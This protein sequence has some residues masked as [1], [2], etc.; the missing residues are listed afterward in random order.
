MQTTHSTDRL[1]LAPLVL[2]DHGFMLELV[3][4]PGWLRYIGD[5]HVTSKEEAISYVERLI[6][7][8]NL[9]YWVVRL[10]ENDM[11]IGVISFIKR[12]YLDHFDI[13]FAML[14]AYARNGYAYESASGVLAIVRQTP[15]HAT[16]LATAMPDNANSIR[17]LTKLGFQFQKE[18]EVNHET[19]HV[20]ST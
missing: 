12:T 19:L 2:T 17:L 6:S 1:T 20:Y 3:N 18:I 8:P 15:Q 11:P 13:G 14:P 7:M 9:T 10:K 16:V 4:S 5:R